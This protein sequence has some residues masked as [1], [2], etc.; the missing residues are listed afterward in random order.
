MHIHFWNQ[1]SAIEQQNLLERPKASQPDSIREKTQAIIDQVREEGDAALID[2]T[3]LHDKVKLTQLT[4]TLA[5]F[6][7][8]KNQIRKEA[9]AAIERAQQQITTYHQAQQPEIRK[10]E[11]A[12][13]IYCERQPRAIDRVG[14]YVPGGSA[15]L[16]ST[17]L[18]L[19]IPAQLAGCSLKVLCTPPNKNGT[20]DPH[21]LYAA[22]LCG[23]QQIFKIGGAQ[24]VAAMAYGTESVPKVDKIFGPGNAFVLAAKMLVSQDA[25]GASIDMPAGPSELLVI[26][27]D[28]ANAD[29]VAAD[30]LSQA[31]HGIDSQVILLTMSVD[32]ANQ[33][34]GALNQQ[35]SQLSRRT[36]AEQ[37]LAHG[38]IIVVTSLEQA[39]SISNRYAPEHLSLQITHPENFLTEIHNAGAVFLGDWSAETMGDYITGS[40]HVLPTS[41]FARAYSGLSLVDFMKFISFQKVSRPGL[42]ALGPFAEQL[43]E[44]E[45]LDAHRNAVS[46]RLGVDFHPEH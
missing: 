24:A 41:G 35:L 31:E 33:V 42:Q 17:L 28:N 9:L 46:I 2:L 21:L 44:L 39:F 11:T 26:A 38:R 23:I 25:K 40:N 30:L 20:I 12:P 13:G 37:S 43:A 3:V 4:T 14:L 5:E 34:H 18:M 6:S 27:D 22:E 36:I 8:A 45:G 19:A 29:F 7:A 1:L 15:P 32:F 10:I 16:I